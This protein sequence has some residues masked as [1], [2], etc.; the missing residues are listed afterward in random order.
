LAWTA[1]AYFGFGAI[2][3]FAGRSTDVDMALSLVITALIEIKFLVFV[4]LTRAFP[5][6][7]LSA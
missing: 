5:I 4:A 1:A 6:G 3:Q 7:Q 2:G